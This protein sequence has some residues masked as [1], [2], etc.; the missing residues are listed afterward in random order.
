MRER[1]NAWRRISDSLNSIDNPKFYVNQRSVRERFN[2]ILMQYKTKI[3]AEVRATGIEVKEKTSTE[4]LLEEL[5]EKIK[6]AE[7]EFETKTL[8]QSQ[9]GEKE[10]VVVEDVRK[11]ALETLAE[12]KKR[13][14]QEGEVKRTMKSR[15][16]GNETLAYLREKAAKDHEIRILQMK[17]QNEE[18]R[19]QR[20]LLEQYHYQQQQ[21]QQ[22]QQQILLLL[23]NQQQAM[24]TLF[25]KL[26][27]KD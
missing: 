22:T 26:S 9:K 18:A 13:K 21:Q 1:G 6:E 7:A 23:Q 19:A 8:E 4:N 17:T 12:T 10:K 27:K 5:D 3:S 15:T 2:L 20:L 11:K 16:T 24:M 14:Q 25:E